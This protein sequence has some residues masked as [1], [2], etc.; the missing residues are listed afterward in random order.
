M[1]VNLQFEDTIINK[2]TSFPLNLLISSANL[3]G[4]YHTFVRD[5][6]PSKDFIKK[7]GTNG[8]HKSSEK[9]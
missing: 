9:E 5:F 7:N 4:H 8:D 3:L 1:E 6:T 2:L